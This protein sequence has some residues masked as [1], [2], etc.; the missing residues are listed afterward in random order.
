LEPLPPTLD[1]HRS[2]ARFPLGVQLPEHAHER[3][4]GLE[5]S[6]AQH[7]ELLGR[8]LTASFNLR[9]IRPVIGDAV[10]QVVLV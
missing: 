3:A 5:C 10:G 7:G 8:H 9:Q 2:A 6:V 1:G 4:V